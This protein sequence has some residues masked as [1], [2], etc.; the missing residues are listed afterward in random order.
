MLGVLGHEQRVPGLHW[1]GNSIVGDVLVWDAG[2]ASIR[3]AVK[4][5]SM[6]MTS[7]HDDEASVFLCGLGNWK[8][9]C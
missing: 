2:L 6:P 9:N 5:E 4:I 3:D 7:G 1:Q 8:P